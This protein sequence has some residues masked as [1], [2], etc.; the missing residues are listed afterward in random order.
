ML[1]KLTKCNIII[2]K[3]SLND[4]ESV[5]YVDT[6]IRF[7]SGEIKELADTCRHINKISHLKCVTNPK[8]DSNKI[9]IM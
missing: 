1:Q 2:I 5:L 7:K 9:E 4:F 6:S 8:E 3:E